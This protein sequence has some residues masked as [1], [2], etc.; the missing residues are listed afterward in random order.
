[1]TARK[2]DPAFAV[3]GSRPPRVDAADKVTGRAAFGADVKLAG[4]LYGKIL[5][6]PHAHARIVLLDTSAAERLDGVYAVTTAKD[7]PRAA[8][9]TEQLGEGTVNYKY[10]CDATL[11]SEKALF[12]GHPVVGVAARTPTIAEQALQLIMIEYEVL[13]PLLD[14]MDALQEDAPLIHEQMITKSLAKPGVK[15]SNVASHFQHM[16]G[17]PKAG[18]AQADVVIEREFRTATVH[19]GYIE[20]QATTAVWGPDGVLTIYTSTQGPFDIRSQVSTLLQLPM[21]KIRVVPTEVG[22][23]FGG[24]NASYID[25][26]AAVLSRKSGRPVKIVMSR[27]E[28]LMATGPSSG[29]VIQVKMGATKAGKITAAQ[30]TLYYEAGAY[31]GSPVGAG[32]NS[33]FSPYDVPNGQIDGYDII[34]NKPRI[35]SYRAP[36]ATPANFAA[37]T[38]IDELAEKVGLDPLEFRLRNCAREGTRRINGTPH[39]SIG[40]IE[41]LQAAKKHPHYKAPLAGANRGRGIAFGFWGNWGAQSSVNISVNSDGTVA[42]VTGSVDI[43]GTRTSVAMQAA[44]ALEISLDK[45]RSSFT[46]TDAISYGNTSAGSRT[47]MATGVAAVQAARDVIEQMTARAATLW[48]LDVK[49]VAYAAGVFSTSADASLK[50]SFREVAA[51]LGPTGGPIMGRGTVNVTEWGAGM[52]L[53]IADV[54][55]DPETGLVTILRYTAIQDVG[56]A[57]HPGQV[58]GQLQGGATQGIGWALYEA[59]YY[60]AEGRLVN[61]SLLDYK[62]PTFLDVP[63]IDTVIVEVPWPGHPYGVRGVGEVP[64]VTP[65][66]ALGN[67]IYRAIGARQTRLPMSSQHILESMGVI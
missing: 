57:I 53:H 61:T 43:T 9:L 26:V 23:A 25:V 18:F 62:T 38:V 51:K 20:P 59:Y 41:V 7:L 34:V 11:A 47:T 33:M 60:N 10:Q 14:V 64:I 56:R 63:F 12:H 48:A 30:A 45:I 4:T 13:P 50:F 46:D 54:E 16:L 22:G 6:S 49:T 42:L 27:A 58:E 2:K 39:T 65:P 35:G 17:D 55:V 21:A 19:P 29:A 40:A 52:G 8:D 67:A 66:G 28:V 37:E 5:R 15:P 36:G 3:I 31:P 44:E 1:M 32:A 24:K